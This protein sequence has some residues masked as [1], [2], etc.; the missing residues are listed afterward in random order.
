VKLGLRPW[1]ARAPFSDRYHAAAEALVGRTLP[2]G[3]L[4][5]FVS[6]GDRARASDLL[7]AAGID[8]RRPLIGLS[9]GAVWATKRWPLEHYAE[10]ARLALRAGVQVAVQGSAEERPLT[11]RLAVAAPGAADLAGQLD[12]GALGGFIALCSAFVA[13]DTGPMHLARALG[14]PT[15]AFFGSTDPGLFE[16]EGHRVLFTGL[17]CAPCSFFGR[18]R[19]PRG[20]LRCLTGISAAEAWTALQP[21]LDGRRRA[22]LSA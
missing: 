8:V 15:L 4:R 20:H 16:W 19:C 9:P 11:A 3:R 10:L 18:R 14:V 2:R 1:R 12:L 21:L 22:L 5:A 13:N 17:D 6:E 7:R